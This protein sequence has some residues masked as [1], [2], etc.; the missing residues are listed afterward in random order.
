ML[1]AIDQVKSAS[2]KL[3]FDAFVGRVAQKLNRTFTMRTADVQT[4]GAA[5]SSASCA[6]VGT[7]WLALAGVSHRGK[8]I[9][10]SGH[11]RFVGLGGAGSGLVTASVDLPN[12]DCRSNCNCSAMSGINFGCNAH[13]CESDSGVP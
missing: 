4:A 2:T 13:N 7:N 1:I 8:F 10:W 11:D 6:N 12:G 5:E 3:T 9:G